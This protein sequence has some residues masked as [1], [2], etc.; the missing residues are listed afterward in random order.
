MRYGDGFYGRPLF[1]TVATVTLG[2]QDPT[3]HVLHS[4]LKATEG[5]AKDFAD[6]Y[7]RD[8]KIYEAED[9]EELEA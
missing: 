2:V 8:V 7:G 6:R 3:I 4:H 1:E 5:P 9:S